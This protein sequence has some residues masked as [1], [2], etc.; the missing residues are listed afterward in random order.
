MDF[1]QDGARAH[2]D[3]KTIEFFDGND[4][5]VLTPWPAQSPDLNLI[6]NAW[7]FIKQQLEGRI[8]KSKDALWR[9]I[10][11]EWDAM[12]LDFIRNLFL[13][14]PNRLNSVIENFGGHTKY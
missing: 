13:S 8:I 11:S 14:M 7:G 4:V 9:A 12:P 5:E 2:T 1:Q 6:E 3:R 10:E